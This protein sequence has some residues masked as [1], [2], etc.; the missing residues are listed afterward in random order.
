MGS[1]FI[2][3]DTG[4]TRFDLVD[5]VFYK[6]IADVLTLGARKYDP[7]NWKQ[8][9]EIERYIAAA[10]RHWNAY[11]RGE[12]LDD[13]SQLPHVIHA[14]VNLMFIRWHEEAKLDSVKAGP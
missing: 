12:W 8:C 11:R 4:K 1:G 6:E 10:E 5:P 2:K 9:K 14:A 13:E 3:H 7:H